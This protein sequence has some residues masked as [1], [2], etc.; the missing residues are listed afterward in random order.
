MSDEHLALL[1]AV[2]ANAAE[3]EFNA[4]ALAWELIDADERIG[5][6]VTAGMTFE[7]LNGLI[8]SLFDLKTR[9]ASIGARHFRSARKFA[10]T[11][12]R[13]RNRLLHGHWRIQWSADGVSLVTRTRKGMLDVRMDVGEENIRS[14]ADNLDGAASLY[15]V[16]HLDLLPEFDRLTETSP[17]SGRWTRSSLEDIRAREQGSETKTPGFPQSHTSTS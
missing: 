3:L 7:R 15:R 1:G 9:P 8:E 16:A 4:A 14:V 5:M 12:M 11:A 13:E 10:E 17:G 6:A 2:S